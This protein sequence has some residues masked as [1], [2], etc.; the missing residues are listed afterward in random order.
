MVRIKSYKL[1]MDNIERMY[2]LFVN[3]SKRDFTIIGIDNYPNDF[4]NRVRKGECKYRGELLRTKILFLKSDFC[5]KL[6][7]SACD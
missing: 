7:I 1:T 2:T 4:L 6:M 3:P 5:V